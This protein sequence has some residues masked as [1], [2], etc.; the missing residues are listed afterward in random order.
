MPTTKPRYTITDTGELATMLDDAHRRWPDMSD[1][2]QLLLRLAAEGHTALSR[3]LE[4]ADDEVRRERQN[5][6]FA[7]IRDLVDADALLADAAWR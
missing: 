7:C 2:K 5:H 3:E 4:R 6:A 1:R